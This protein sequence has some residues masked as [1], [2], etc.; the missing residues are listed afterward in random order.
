LLDSKALY[1]YNS[2]GFASFPNISKDLINRVDAASNSLGRK[3]HHIT[4]IVQVQKDGRK[5][6][7]GLPVVNNV[8]REAVF[9]INNNN[10]DSLARSTNLV[11]YNKNVDDNM[12]N[13]NGL[14]N[15][16]SSTITPTYTTANLL[17]G[18]LS[19]DYIDV[20]GDGI[21]D[22][23]LGSF[24]KFNYSRKSK[25]Y[26]WRSPAQVNKASY[27][28]AFLAD[29]KDDKAAYTIGSR[30]QWY[31]HSMETKNYVA[32]FYVSPREDAKGVLDAILG[33]SAT[34]AYKDP[35]YKALNTAAD[36]KSYKLD[37]IVLY[38]KHDRFLNG[39]AAKAIKSVY[40]TYDYSLCPGVPNSTSGKLTLKAIQFKFGD[41]KMNL[42][43]PYTFNYTNNYAYHPTAKDRWD[44]YKPNLAGIGNTFYPFTEQSAN[45]NN[46]AKA[47]SLS[48]ISLPSGGVIK[49]DYEADD[50]AFVQEKRAMEM[51]KV[52]GFGNSK[53][54]SSS[55]Q[56][57]TASTT[58]N[59]YLYFTRRKTDE[60]PYSTFKDN[61]LKE[62]AL[63]YYNI[64]V[65][66]KNYVYENIKGYANITEVGACADSIHGYLKMEAKNLEN[67]APGYTTSPESGCSP[68]R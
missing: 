44:M 38:T 60:N 7:Y 65:Q 8:Q 50:Y 21:S 10:A 51:F 15:F 39:A 26:R 13:V 67:S 5:Y 14:D 6:I 27:I 63:L 30:E 57:Y 43:A 33:N 19:S 68:R 18:V 1:S 45:T 53:L 22:D 36:N 28:P 2:N 62:S 47:W 3:A 52:D 20:T 4:E 61:Y 37:S 55:N 40:F 48:D 56:L 24:T 59:L 17:T 34:A 58:P 42:S 66:L 31:L 64:P 12:G 46:Y 35:I 54:F 25:D 11:N 41:S 29:K 49:V 23:D 32:E 16:Y 9:A